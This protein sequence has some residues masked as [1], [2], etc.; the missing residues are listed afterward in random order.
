MAEYLLE[1]LSEEIPARMQSRAADDL[2]RMVTDG[3]GKNGIGFEAARAYVTP[4]RLVLVIEGLPLAGPDVSEEKRGPRV[5]SPA[6]AMDGFLKSTGMTVEQLEQR[7]TGKG[8]FYFAVINKKGRPTAEV[9]TEVVQAAMADFPWPKS[10]RWGANAVRWVRPVQSIISLLDGQVVPVAFG[11]VAAGDLTAGH[12]FLAPETFRVKDFADYLNKLR[13]AKVML[14][15]VER[16]HAILSGAEA[17]AAAEGLTLKADD[18]LL[19]EVSGLVEWP[20]PLI[21][22][23]DDA[24]M[25]VPAEV[26]ITSMR[27]HQKYFSLLKADGSLAPR[28]IVV[29]NMETSDGGKAVVAGNQRVLRARLSDAKFFWDTDRK[30]SLQSRLGKLDERLFY[31]KLGTLADKVVRIQN[32]VGAMGFMSL[33]QRTN[34]LV[35]AT[36]CKADL[37]SEMVG[38]F[39]E[40]QGIMGRY[41]ALNDGLNPEVANAIAEHYS[42]L[43]PSD[44]CPTA[45]ASVAVSLADKI[46]S[47]VGF[48]GIDEKPTGSKDPFALRRAALGVIRLIVENGLRVSLRTLFT[49][50]HKSFE[51]ALTADAASV[52]SDLMAFF[53]DRLTVALKEKGVRHDLINAVFALGGEDDLVRLLARV[54]ALA[55]FL[56]SDDGANLLVAYRRAAN[57]VRIEEKKDG[58]TYTGTPEGLQLPEEKALAEALAG[59]GPQV[60]AALKAEDF[61]AAMAALATLRRPLDAFFDKVTVNADDPALRVNRLKLLAAIG[62]AMGRLADVSKVEG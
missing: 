48:F 47:L 3:L 59:I 1:I 27:S 4:R 53:A 45:L 16:R 43:G 28:F 10:M 62:A 57:I 37:S 50:A 6:Q 9:L 20:V 41:Y 35:A 29:S 7:D 54:D 61:Q 17:L 49:E 42:P 24:F 58:V 19:A 18:G 33:E 30:H 8:V 32:L 23:I 60:D 56:A 26:L 22:S 39:P 13:H 31:A 21:G 15:P 40:L 34:A 25:D 44:S 36:L 55:A 38:E 12:R 52:A 5:G 14:D 11:P 46:D 2:H 51:S